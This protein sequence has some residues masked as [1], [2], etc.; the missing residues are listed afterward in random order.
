MSLTQ[1]EIEEK[2]LI[3]S[4]SFDSTLVLLRHIFLSSEGI[5]RYP[6]S[7]HADPEK[8]TLKDNFLSCGDMDESR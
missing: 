5:S 3:L 4:Q 1:P 8:L 2:E 7:Y 6:D